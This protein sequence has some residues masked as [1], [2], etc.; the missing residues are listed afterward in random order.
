M[1]VRLIFVIFSKN[2]YLKT[3]KTSVAGLI[4]VETAN[5][6]GSLPFMHEMRYSGA[7]GEPFKAELC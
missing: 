3:S 6:S 7:C 2:F 4:W 1:V 5:F